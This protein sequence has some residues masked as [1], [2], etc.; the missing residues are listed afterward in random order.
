MN[1][2]LTISS[3]FVVLVIQTTVFATSS[4]SETTISNEGQL[5]TAIALANPGD[6]LVVQDGTYQDW[7]IKF[8]SSGTKTDP[9]TLKA[10]TP[11]GVKLSGQV[12]FEIT[13]QYLVVAGFLF[14]DA[15]GTKHNSIVEFRKAQHCR[16]TNCAFVRC[17]DPQ[18]TF[19][20]TINLAYG[21][22]F[23]RVDHCFMTGTLSMGMG[24]TIRDSAAGQG[25]TDNRFDHNYF[26]DIKR[27]SSNGQ[28]PIQ[29]GQNQT[30]YGDVSIHAV[31]EYN[32]F[33]NASGD[34]EI[35]SNKS[36][37]NII[38]YN[39]MRD[40]KAGICLRG[41]RNTVVEG[42]YCF[43]TRGIR[44]FG[45]GHRV[46][47]NYL[48]ETEYG[49]SLDAGQYRDGDFVN[50]ETS[51]SYQAASNVLVAYNTIVDPTDSGISLGR[52]RGRKHQ[53]VL[54]NELPYSTSFIN[55][56]ITG[57]RG[58][59]IDDVG[60][61]NISWQTNIVWPYEK[62]KHGLSHQGIMIVDP[63]LKRVNNHRLTLGT[64]SA[65]ENAGIPLSKVE[66]DL[67]GQKRDASPDIGCDEISRIPVI[68]QALQPGDV[69]CTWLH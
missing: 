55:N 59:L 14:D 43:R 34:S 11:G 20:R 8:N 38:R 15:I 48:Q 35:I 7:R 22:R 49:I 40:S 1:M 39:T 69:G 19:T 23:N 60:S 33:E 37:D 12:R 57:N 24:V 65:A 56:L 41:G 58:L 25:N 66:L 26:K 6:T 30:A 53:G 61:R 32:L 9:V 13:G 4:G 31:V 28:E 18:S 2:R 46:V 36:A 44:V 21:S 68:N 50:R 47:N 51:G 64:P 62:A 27:L 29:L 54:R 16:L 42:N 3:V 63:R 52:N 45:S 17:G 10:Q 5:V 67:S